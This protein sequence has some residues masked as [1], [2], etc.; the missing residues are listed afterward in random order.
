M[1]LSL[2]EDSNER[3]YLSSVIFN[4]EAETFIDSCSGIFQKTLTDLP[5]KPADFDTFILSLRTILI[6]Q[7]ALTLDDFYTKVIPQIRASFTKLVVKA[8]GKTKV[9]GIVENRPVFVNNL[10]EIISKFIENVEIIAPEVGAPHSQTVPTS[11]STGL[12]AEDKA[13]IQRANANIRKSTGA[14]VGTLIGP[15]DFTL[16][17][18]KRPEPTPQKRTKAEQALRAEENRLALQHAADIK[19]SAVS[20]STHSNIGR[21][22]LADIAERNSEALVYFN[23]SHYIQRLARLFADKAV[24][25]GPIPLPAHL[26]GKYQEEYPNLAGQTI[27]VQDPDDLPRH[28]QNNTTLKS[29][30]VMVYLPKKNSYVACPIAF[31]LDLSAEQ[32]DSFEE[33]DDDEE[34]DDDYRQAA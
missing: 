12:S 24:I 21:Y 17:P 20:T 16:R 13:A 28:I 30:E 27:E 22:S 6:E 25:E 9:E 34:I 5:I 2:P 23:K 33:E 11:P 7:P 29:S 14:R 26:P 1:T 15:P 10:N 3:Q 32:E 8:Y 19:I 31:I 18:V 4:K